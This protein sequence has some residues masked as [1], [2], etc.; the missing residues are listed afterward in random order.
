MMGMAIN[1]ILQSIHI[2]KY[3]VRLSKLTLVIMILLPFSSCTMSRDTIKN[4][5]KLDTSVR[6]GHLS[7]GFT[8]YLKSTN[9]TDEISL[10]FYVKV[11]DYNERLPEF[12][13][14]HLIEHIAGNEVYHHA[15]SDTLKN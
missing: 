3:L 11:G 4:S 1:L 15:N 2:M 14:A 6:M 8:Y 10:R 7:N 13:F 9:N 12:Q 5:F